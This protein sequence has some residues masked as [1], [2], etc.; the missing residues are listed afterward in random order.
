MKIKTD[1]KWN[2]LLKQWKAAQVE[3]ASRMIVQPLKALP[4]YVCGAD[5][6]FS[7]DDVFAVAVVYDREED[8]V[9]EITQSRRKLTAPYIPTFLSFRE[10]D[11]LEEAISRLKHSFGI[12]CFDGQGY[13]HPRRCGLATHMGVKLDQPSIGCGKSRLIGTFEEPALIKGADSPLMDGDEQVGIVLRTRTGFRPMYVSVGHRVDLPGAKKLVLAC[14]T[15]YRM[16]E[17]TRLADRQVARVK[18]TFSAQ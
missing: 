10:G 18:A 17:P 2:D 1:P 4:R 3:L 16:P 7:K 14:C 8:Q 9:V 12:I 5:A 11:V 6:A 13:A 15:R